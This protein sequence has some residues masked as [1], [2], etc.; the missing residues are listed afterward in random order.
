MGIIEQKLANWQASL[1]PSIPISGLFA[2]NAVAYKWKAPFRCWMLREA[3]FC[4]LTDLL[5]QSNALHIQGYGLGSRILLRSGFETLAIL[6]YLN[7]LI[8]QVLEGELNF[9]V[10]SQKTST[11]LLGSRDGSTEL[12]SLNIVTIFGKCNK[13]YPGI[14]KI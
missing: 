11:L 6:V 7:K 10:F 13:Q 4:R 2:R 12:N 5:T 8:E 14:E 1:M 9:H 3:T